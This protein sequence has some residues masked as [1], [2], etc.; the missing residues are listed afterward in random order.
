MKIDQ[1]DAAKRL[2]M[3][4]ESI[5]VHRLNDDDGTRVE[6]VEGEPIETAF[7]EVG[8]VIRNKT[9][10]YIEKE[11]G[12]EAFADK[13]AEADFAVVSATIG[14]A[15]GWSK[16]ITEERLVETLIQ[17]YASAV[18]AS[19]NR[20][21]GWSEDRVKKAKAAEA[22]INKKLDEMGDELMEKAAEKTLETFVEAAEEGPEA[23]AKAAASVSGLVSTMSQEAKAEVEKVAETAS[24]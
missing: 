23:L 6:Y 10:R 7:E 4:P 18:T 9:I 8:L 14:H 13:L 11:W 1:L 21:R 16:S 5:V 20:T 17:E 12:Q 3:V 2:M 19:W 24:Q 15:L 22:R